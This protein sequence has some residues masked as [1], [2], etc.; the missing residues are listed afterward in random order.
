MILDINGTI[1]DTTI[2]NLIENN[3]LIW[4]RQERL[5]RYFSYPG[6]KNI[7]IP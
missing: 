2:G 7:N 3:Q 5:Y 4:N 6:H 1:T